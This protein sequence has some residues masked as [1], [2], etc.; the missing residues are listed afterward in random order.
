[1]L[2]RLAAESLGRT[3]WTVRL[4]FWLFCPLKEG[5]VQAQG[6]LEEL[7]AECEEMQRLWQEENEQ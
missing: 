5:K 2:M 7:L 4:P 1:M 3:E 6:R